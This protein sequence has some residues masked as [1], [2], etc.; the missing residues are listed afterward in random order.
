[1]SRE[2][3]PKVVDDHPKY[4]SGAQLDKELLNP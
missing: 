4:D 2:V 3:V 1:M